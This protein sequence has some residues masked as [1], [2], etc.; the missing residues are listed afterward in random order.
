MLAGKVTLKWHSYRILDVLTFVTMKI[1][2]LRNLAPCNLVDN[3]LDEITASACAPKYGGCKFLQNVGTHLPD[4]TVS[5]PATPQYH[6][7]RPFK[8]EVS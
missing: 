4:Y 1:T 2:V 8:S 6:P 5:R 7:P 3:V